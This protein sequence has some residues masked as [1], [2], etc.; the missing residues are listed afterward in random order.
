M[1]TSFS[2]EEYQRRYRAV[3]HLL[4]EQDL[5][6]VICYA[7]RA[8]PGMI[9]YL[10][11]FTARHEAYMLVPRDEQLP[12]TLLVQLY[13][14]VP[15]ARRISRVADTRWGGSDS[16]PTLVGQ[17]AALGLGGKRLGIH[18]PI[19][20]AR[21]AQLTKLLADTALVDITGSLNRLRWVK[22][23]EEIAILRQAAALT[24]QG[25][26][27]LVA[28]I[29]PGVRDC[30]LLGVL[31]AA[32]AAEG[33]QVDLCFL[34]STA[35]DDPAVYVP[36]QNLSTRQIATGD[37]IITEIGISREGYAGQIHRPIAVGRP[38]NRVYQALYD[39][40]LEAYQM[41]CAAIR[42]GGSVEEVLD[43]A[44]VIQARGYT[45]CDDLVHGFGGGYLPPVLRTRQT[46]A[47]P[48]APFT[49]AENMCIVVQPNIIDQHERAGVQLGQLHVVTTQGLEPLHRYPLEFVVV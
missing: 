19:P 22:S 48:A 2:D 43:A 31:Q 11:G 14:H 4:V 17:I 21:Y 23:T 9:E 41:V 27:A 10:A 24:D 37:C 15:N 12:V 34:A 16:L 46:M 29:R 28:A 20:F 32:V 38:P 30:E 5:D 1:K 33:G 3:R 25:V 44:E 13:N 7:A 47:E 39:V 35:M 6:G 36:A 49:F 45:I 18:G 8:V 40:A 42:V 26:A